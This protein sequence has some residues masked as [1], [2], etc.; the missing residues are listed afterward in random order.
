[1]KY[2]IPFLLC[3]TFTLQIKSQDKK[4]IA[5]VYFERAQQSYEQKDFEKTTDYLEKTKKYYEG[6]IKE[7]V[8]IFGAKY[9]HEQNNYEKS[10]EYLKAFFLLQNNK[11]SNIYKEMLLLYTANLDALENPENN[12]KLRLENQRKD[13]LKVAYNAAIKNYKSKNYAKA[14]NNITKFVALKPNLNSKELKELTEILEII[15]GELNPQEEDAIIIEDQ[16]TITNEP[17][18]FLIIEEVPIYPGCEGSKRN[19][20]DCFSKKVQEH[21]IEHF[22]ADLPNKLGLSSGRKKVLITFKID[23]LGDIVNIGARAPHV[24][25]K[26][27]AIRVLKLMPKM[28]PGKQ[29][30]KPVSVSY[31]IPFSIIVEGAKKE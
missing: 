30:G 7:D 23:K 10:Q 4:A 26:E 17:T 19:L 2:L 12:K 5:N 18:S 3:L 28:L 9:Y 31:S 27:E 20:K 13:S 8:A 11:G 6:I 29:E 15:N 21:F 22:D 1:M 14:I 24:K 16:D 25:I